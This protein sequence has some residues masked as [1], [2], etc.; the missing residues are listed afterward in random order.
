MGAAGTV[1]RRGTQST[2]IVA[3]GALGII[4]C[5]LPWVAENKVLVIAGWS[6]HGHERSPK[7]ALGLSEGISGHMYI[8]FLTVMILCVVAGVLY[9]AT[10]VQAGDAILKILGVFGVFGSIGS[11]WDLWRSTNGTR[12]LVVIHVVSSLEA[13]FWLGAFASLAIA[14]TALIPVAKEPRK[15]GYPARPSLYDRRR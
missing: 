2:V 14:I 11:A 8:G 5:F 3:L 13:G 1:I 7:S 6:I 10:G 12:E 9:G 15:R 4:S